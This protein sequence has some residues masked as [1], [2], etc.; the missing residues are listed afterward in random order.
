VPRRQDERASL[1]PT[2]RSRAINAQLDM[3]LAYC[4]TYA[5]K[6]ASAIMLYGLTWRDVIPNVLWTHIPTIGVR[7][8]GLG[9]APP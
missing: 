8:R 5:A 7:A 6:V 4:Q 9:A 3:F 1:T 2:S